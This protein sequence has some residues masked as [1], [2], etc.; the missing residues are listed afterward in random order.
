MIFGS[1]RSRF[2]EFKVCTL[3]PLTYMYHVCIS[4]GLEDPHCI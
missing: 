1:D 3:H 4:H 2:Y